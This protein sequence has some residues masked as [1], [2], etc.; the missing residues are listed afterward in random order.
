MSNIHNIDI[1]LQDIVKK[2]SKDVYLIPKFQRDFVWT[3]K[4]IIDLGDSIIRGYPISSLLIMP[5]NGNLKIGYHG[6]LKDESSLNI[7]NSEEDSETKYYVLDGQQRMTSISKLFLSLDIR[8]EYYYDLLSILMERFPEDKIEN[9]SGLN[10]SKAKINQEALCRSFNRGQDKSDK[11]TRDNNRFISGKSIIENKFGSVVS[12]F[13]RNLKDIDEDKFDKYMDYL[14][15][16]LG[17]VSG[18]SVPATVISGDSELGVVIR[19]FEKVNSTGKKLTLF[20]LINAKSFQVQLEVYK[21]GLSTFLN[22]KID[23]KISSNTNLK[24]GLQDFFKYNEDSEVY[25]KLD[26]IIRIFE[27][28]HLLE[29]N[30]IPNLVQSN[31]LKRNAEF[32]FEMWNKKSHVLFNIIQWIEEENLLDIGQI[33]FLEYAIAIFLANPQSFEN[34]RFK[35]DVKKYALYLTIS[36]TNF[37]KSNL[38]TVEK[39]YDISKRVVNE[40]EFKKYDFDALFSTPN[41]TPSKVLEITTTKA[42]FRA[43]LNILY[44]E[45]PKGKFDRDILGN[46]VL[47]VNPSKFDNHHIYPK[48]RVS[49]FSNKSPYNSIANIVLVDSKQNREEI[50]DK[51]PSDYFKFIENLEGGRDFS[52]ANL[53]DLNEALKVSSNDDALMFITSRA[54]KIA[55]MINFFFKN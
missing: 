37:S 20:D 6:L 47:K 2:I 19:V 3:S 23:D 18:Y 44:D 32:W 29:Q 17:A 50:K 26:R 5:E 7:V 48:T 31:M 16:I 52:E 9:D 45:K 30:S 42:E 27:I 39:L 46:K 24:I 35:R 51:T 38:D 21:G 28:A 10:S 53:I 55:E 33:T 11:P 4:D 8:N 13:L 36:N 41:L 14:N 43:V 34:A 22:N 15:G 54:N 1:S 25:E 12:K 49:D 40:H